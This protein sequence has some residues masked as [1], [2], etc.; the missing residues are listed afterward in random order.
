MKPNLVRAAAFGVFA[1][2]ACAAAHAGTVTNS[3]VA[4][5]SRSAS[6][7]LAYV[8]STADA[9]QYIEC[10]S[11]ASIQTNQVYAQCV[12]RDAAGATFS[13]SSQ[14]PNI[15]AVARSISNTSFITVASDGNLPNGDR[16]CTNLFV[17]NSSRYIP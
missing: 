9:T 13:C 3:A 11:G 15:I 12:A 6:G 16:E 17:Y 8:R 5:D 7:S 4:I 2:V 14:N 10:Y 1:I